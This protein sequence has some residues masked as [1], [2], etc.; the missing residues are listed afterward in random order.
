MTIREGQD[1]MHGEESMGADWGDRYK[2]LEDNFDETLMTQKVYQESTEN[3]NTWIKSLWIRYCKVTEKHTIDTLKDLPISVVYYFFHWVLQLRRTR[4]NTVG[5]LQTY[6]NV[7]G[8]VRKQMT[9]CH[10]IDPLI[11]SQMHGVRQRLA[12][13]FKLRSDP[14]P[15]PIMRS[16]DEFELLKTLWTSNNMRFDHERHRLELACIVQLAGI[17]GNRPDALLSMKYKD[18]KVALLRN[19]NGGEYPRPI[20]DAK[21]GHTKSYLGQ[22]QANT[23]PIVDISKEPCLLLCPQTTLLSLAF[24]DQ[25]FAAPELNS[26]EQFFRLRV[27]EGLNE[28]KVP[29]KDEI[30]DVPV[31]RRSVRTILGVTISKTAALADGWLRSHMYTLGNVTGIDLPTGPYTFRRGNGE[32][33]DNSSYISDA[34]RNLILQHSDS[35]VF[36]KNYLSHYITVDTQAAY[37]GLEPQTAL[38]RAAS[39]M[40]RSIDRRRPMYLTKIQQKEVD[41]RPEV[42]LLRRRMM[43]LKPNGYKKQDSSTHQTYQKAYQELQSLR[44]RLFKSTLREER[45]RFNREQPVLDIQR[46]LNPDLSLKN[47]K[48]LVPDRYIFKERQQAVEALMTFATTSPEEEHKR[49]AR[50]IQAIVKLSHLQEGPQFK[51]RSNAEEIEAV[52]KQISPSPGEKSIFDDLPLNFDNPPRGN[53]TG[54]RD[55]PRESE[56]DEASCDEAYS[57][58]A[59]QTESDEGDVIEVFVTNKKES[60]VSTKR[61]RWSPAEDELLIKFKNIEKPWGFIFRQFPERSHASVSSRWYVVL[62]SRVDLS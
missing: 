31:F 12:N 9:G 1:V 27:L 54:E 61:G 33:L 14:K 17:T 29:F 22:K 59:S 26:P 25:A 62:R 7:L 46:Q 49:R 24:A 21:F 53:D 35:K 2:Q 57:R 37:R 28:Q 8:N 16:E 20:I 3:L 19:P 39:G 55:S 56:D 48:S 60:F 41:N 51:S 38:I 13:E 47:E 6:W 18:L 15:K 42:K 52:D 23:H 11:K 30:L 44:R 4:I 43:N 10:I 36:Q 50:A 40:S 32:A 58:Q 5:T 45:H 34:Q